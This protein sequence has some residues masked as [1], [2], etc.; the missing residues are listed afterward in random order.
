MCD[1]RVQTVQAVQTFKLF[2]KMNPLVCSFGVL[3]YLK[4]LNELHSVDIAS[5]RRAYRETLFVPYLTLC[6]QDK[7]CP[8]REEDFL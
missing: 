7:D 5:T 4:D 6:S 8:V 2:K 1:K 3:N